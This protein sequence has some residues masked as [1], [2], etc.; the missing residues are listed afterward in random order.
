MKAGRMTLEVS[1]LVAG[2]PGLLSAIELQPDTL[3]AWDDYIRNAD[4][5]MQSRLDGRRPFLWTDEASDRGA[6][7]R[8]GE[9]L[10]V[11]INGHG[12]QS[13][14]NGLIHDWLGAAFIPNATIEGLLAV[15]H[16]YGR[17]K[18]FYGP[19]V[20]DSK[21]L[22]CSETDQRF[23][24]V[25]QHRVL[26]VDAAIEGQYQASDFALDAQHGYNIANTT[27]LRE[28]ES[29]GKSG[30]YLLPPGQ[31]S[32]FIWRLHSIARYEQRDGGV[33]LELEAIAL[34]RTIPSSLR[35][36]V[37][38]VVNHLSINSLMT[39][40]RQTRDAVVSLPQSPER[41]ASCAIGRHGFPIAKN[42]G[43]E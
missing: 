43:V 23:S 40:L 33:Y 38:P 39:S 12:A 19:V 6:R 24:M 13:V 2:F 37:T 27:Q 26:F 32:G 31:G 21:V 30:E 42:G 22:A 8:Q 35:W 28:I 36:V 9:I 7:L 11:P 4:S 10:V 41:I 1:L 34:T 20:A 15:V 3:K 16:D 5:H 18:E 25:W 17:Y 29:Y 14:A